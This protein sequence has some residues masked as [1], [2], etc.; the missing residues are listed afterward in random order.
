M[1]DKVPK[2]TLRKRDQVWY[3]YYTKPDGKRT[4]RST[5]T[6]KK[7]QAEVWARAWLQEQMEGIEPAKKKTT[8][9]GFL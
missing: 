5:G 3:V 7:A 6:R 8:L 1:P 9:K 4:A 2:Y